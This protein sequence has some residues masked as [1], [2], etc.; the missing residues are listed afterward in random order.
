MC[1]GRQVR[2]DPARAGWLDQHLAATP[3]DRDGSTIIC[4][5]TPKR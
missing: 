4:F 2:I 3:D 1:T 5:L